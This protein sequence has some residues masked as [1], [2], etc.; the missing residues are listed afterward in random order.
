MATRAGGGPVRSGRDQGP[1]RV[2]LIREH[3]RLHPETVKCSVTSSEIRMLMVH[4][5]RG[6]GSTVDAAEGLD[7]AIS[8]KQARALLAELESGHDAYR[9]LLRMLRARRD[10]KS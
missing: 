10:G 8:A 6:I 1:S 3:F 4:A 2:D 5:F 7:P 9:R